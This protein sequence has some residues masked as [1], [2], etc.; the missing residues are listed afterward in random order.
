M[1]FIISDIGKN[2]VKITD[3]KTDFYFIASC[4]AKHLNPLY[5]KFIFN[6]AG[7]YINT[8]YRE[9]LLKTYQ[10]CRYSYKIYLIGFRYPN[11]L[12]TVVTIN[13]KAVYFDNVP[14]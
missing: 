3:D 14:K 2:Q 1:S 11:V 6:N 12:K 10:R 4:N 13:D 5:I 7:D 8:W 9:D